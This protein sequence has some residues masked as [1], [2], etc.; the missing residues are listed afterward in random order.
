MEIAFLLLTDVEAD[1]GFLPDQFVK[2]DLAIFT[3][4]LHFNLE[5]PADL[6]FRSQR[7]NGQRVGTQSSLDG[8]QTCFL[9]EGHDSLGDRSVQRART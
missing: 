2:L 7:A 6:L 5:H 3:A 9:C 1:G 8:E 4:Q